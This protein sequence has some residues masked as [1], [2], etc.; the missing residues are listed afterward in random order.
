MRIDRILAE[1]RQ[2]ELA[3][4]QREVANR[5]GAGSEPGPVSG[6][7]PVD[8]VEISDAGRAMAMQDE[9]K[10]AGRELTPER[11]AELRERIRAGTYDQP[12][13]VSQVAS[14]ILDSG[15]A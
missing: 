8:R 6:V 7:P 2:A 1:A 12:E 10:A 3:R 5:A 14:R 13:I 9:V 4:Q 15:D 11:I